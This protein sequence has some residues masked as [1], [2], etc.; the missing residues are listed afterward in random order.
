[1]DSRFLTCSATQALPILVN[2]NYDL[3]EHLS[4]VVIM[5]HEVAMN[6]DDFDAH[7]CDDDVDESESNM[8]EK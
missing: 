3:I 4:K 1:M 6:F 8:E 5:M 7:D 2:R